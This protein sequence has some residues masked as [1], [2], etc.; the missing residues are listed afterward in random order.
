MTSSAFE[1]GATGLRPVCCVRSMSYRGRFILLVTATAV[2]GVL[3][4]LVCIYFLYRTALDNQI[5]HLRLD[6]MNQR[7]LLE[8][9]SGSLMYGSLSGNEALAAALAALRD[10]RDPSS[11]LTRQYHFCVARR[12]DG[13]FVCASEDDGI[14]HRIPADGAGSEPYRRAFEGERGT[15]VHRSLSGRTLLSAFEPTQRPDLVIVGSVDLAEVRRPYLWA[16]VAV[17]G[18]AFSLTLISTGSLRKL[19]RDLTRDIEHRERKFQTLFEFSSDGCFLLQERFLDCNDEGCRILGY[20]REEII[21]R[22]PAELSPPL[23]ADGQPSATA[24][25]AR[26][27]AALGGSPQR[28]QWTHRHRDGHDLIVEVSLKSLPLEEDGVLHASIR[29]ITERVRTER[30]LRLTQFL[31]DQATDAIFLSQDDDSLSYV[32]PAACEL[33]GYTESELLDLSLGNLCSGP[34]TFVSRKHREQLGLGARFTTQAELLHRSGERIPVEVHMSLFRFEGESFACA[35]VHDLR[36]HRNLQAQLLQAQKLEAVGRLA[37]GVA[38]DFNNLLTIIGGYTD[39]LLDQQTGDD[40]SPD[41]VALTEI[42]SASDRAADLT[43]QL[44]TFSRKQIIEPKTLHLNEVIG[45]MDRMLRRL[46][47]EDIEFSTILRPNLSAVRADP[48]QLEQVFLNLCVNARDAMP[49]GGKLTIETDEVSLDAAYADRKPGVKPGHYV[50]L[51]VS[52]TGVGMD[53][54]TQSRIFEPFFT[55]KGRDKG[56]GLGLSTVYGIIKRAGGNVWVYSEPNR[57]TT[58]KIY[59]PRI[60]SDSN[61]PPGDPA[62]PTEQHG[63]ETILVVEDDDHVRGLVV[64]E[65][66][67]LGY[68]VLS[69]SSP[70]DALALTQSQKTP[71]DLLLTDVVLPVISGK[72]LAEQLCAERPEMGVLFMSGYTDSAIAQHGMLEEGV[73]FLQKPFS[74]QGLASKV[75]EI[76]SRRRT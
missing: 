56:T 1:T 66:R 30:R 58:F 14:S 53:Q 65:L 42:R 54:E 31:N 33:L 13:A 69:A 43:R 20:P 11:N 36:E 51:A 76:L 2:A 68:T 29:D 12:D 35:Y 47:G 16:A 8:A 26:V 28:F 63:E 39:M 57:G 59:L 70:D 34:E 38:H 45:G 17:L 15:V 22:T 7:Q 49:E 75:R 25:Q 73:Y 4:A 24:A 46:I 27:Q 41:R 19:G 60:G 62:A 32:N 55:T 21:G 72:V 71:I 67:T 9:S 23:Q 10:S 40:G 61:E 37:G 64:T 6:L 50:M 5:S 48:A 52:D 74:K 44:L 3:I 18:V